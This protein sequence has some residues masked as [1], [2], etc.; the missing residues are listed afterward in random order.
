MLS[1]Q[2]TQPSFGIKS[3]SSF[4]HS[5]IESGTSK[6]SIKLSQSPP[7]LD[8]VPCNLIHDSTS[9]CKQVCEE[10]S[11]PLEA[12]IHRTLQEFN[13]PSI[14]PGISPL[15]FFVYQIKSK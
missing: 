14:Q 5:Q 10:I 15:H 3:L 8:I 2:F 9:F 11:S 13:F 6:Q 4:C 7:P 12:R 1:S